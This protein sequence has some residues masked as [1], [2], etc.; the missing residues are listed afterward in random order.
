MNIAS[1]STLPNIT[2]HQSGPS[3]A[4]VPWCS[5]VSA[6]RSFQT[7]WPDRYVQSS[8]VT[9][10]AT[11]SAYAVFKAFVIDDPSVTSVPVRNIP[12]AQNVRVPEGT[13]IRNPATRAIALLDEWLADDSGYD[14][15]TWPE[16]KAALDR[17]RLSAR[18]LFD[19]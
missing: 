2:L 8:G 19:G 18:K 4:N 13:A 17:D 3:V 12:I 7:T 1:E 10:S 9:I 6:A 15:E 14:E 16:I 11:A 5:P